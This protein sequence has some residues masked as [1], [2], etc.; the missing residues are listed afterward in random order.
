M[1]TDEV[2]EE[3]IKTIPDAYV[4]MILEKKGTLHTRGKAESIE[5]C[6][7]SMLEAIQ[8]AEWED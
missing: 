4:V 8:T 7:L 3:V 6:H 1:V 2:L 5:E